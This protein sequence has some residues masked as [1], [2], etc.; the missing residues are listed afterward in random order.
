MRKRCSRYQCT[1]CNLYAMINFIAVFQSTQ[2]G[3]RV[4]YARLVY[5]NRLESSFQCGILFNVLTV[6]IQ[7]CRTDAVQLT[8]CQHWL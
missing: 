1:V 6:L 7:R 4:F 5:H 2:N 3:N 8:S